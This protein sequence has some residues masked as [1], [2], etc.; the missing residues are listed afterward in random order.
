MNYKGILLIGVL[1]S[2]V[3]LTHAQA[4]KNIVERNADGQFVL[5]SLPYKVDALTPVIGEETV[6]LHYGKHFQGYINNLNKLIVGTPFENSS[7]EEIVVYATGPIFNN[8]A[9]ALNHDIYFNTFSPDAR[10]N[11]SG[12]LLAAINKKWGSF[13]NFKKEFETA[14]NGLFG[15]G[16][17]WL[18][19]TPQGELVILTESNAGN[20]L[21]RGY[22]PLL[23]VDVW[24]HAYYL[25]YQNRRAD[26][27]GGVWTIIDWAK[28]EPRY[29]ASEV[30]R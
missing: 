26:H 11:P 6:K 19:Q 10:Q 18:A 29:Q 3:M 8:A 30:S 21:T 5:S 23:G 27:V 15:A 2:T 16:W 25:D 28:V 1:I 17:A 12:E 22:T 14:A 9:Q 7:L 20:P 13:D 24:E 4:V